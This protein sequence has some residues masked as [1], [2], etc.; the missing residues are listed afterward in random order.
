MAKHSC[1]RGPR[2]RSRLPLILTVVTL[3]PVA[4]AGSL[5]RWSAEPP[6]SAGAPVVATGRVELVA[7]V[8]GADLSVRPVPKFRF[9]VSPANG[10]AESPAVDLVTGFDG[11]ARATVPAGRYRLT[12][13]APLT[14]EGS[15]LSWDITFEVAADATTRIE[16][17]TDN[18]RRSAAP[19]RV[20]DEARVYATTRAA[21]FVVEAN[22]GHGSGFL[23]DPSGLVVTNDHVVSGSRYVAVQLDPATKVPAILLAFD[24]PRDV[25]ILR[26]NPG[27]VAGI[28]P[29]PLASAGSSG[30]TVAEGEKVLAIGNPLDRKSVLT[31]GIVGKVEP[32]TIISDV[33]IN[34]GNSGGPLLNLRGEVVGISTF[35]LRGGGGPGISGILRIHVAEKALSEA[36]DKASTIEPP[37]GE[38]LPVVSPVHFPLD[39]LREKSVADPDFRTYAMDA[40]AIDLHF[41]TPVLLYS[42]NRHAEI[43]ASEVEKNRRKGGSPDLAGLEQQT[44]EWD[45]EDYL[46][47]VTVHA[48]PERKLTGGS[49]AG[50]VFGAMFGVVT[51]GNYRFKARF[52]AM[53]LMRAGEEIRPIFPG[54]SCEAV[55]QSVALGSIEDVGCFGFYQYPPEA[56]E[57]GPALEL[58]IYDEDH[59]DAPEKLSLNAALVRRIWDDFEPYRR[60]VARSTRSEGSSPDAKE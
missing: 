20:S 40:G 19:A 48:L 43:K 25:A 5:A 8:V 32:D 59:G 57:P 1:G 22:A 47:V 18:A 36:R 16:V 39:G 10:S 37:S 14:W 28:Q 42:I 15:D 17:S 7:A 50:R 6:A 44:Y 31:T 27:A 3:L 26:V 29:L 35:G 4:H 60:E 41:L 24:K 58:W 13:V 45:V 9:S 34:P 38:R 12:S 46:P 54:R 23:V 49:K 11:T 51:P 2:G 55:S 33:N 56:F 52:R 21:V 30:S 53:K